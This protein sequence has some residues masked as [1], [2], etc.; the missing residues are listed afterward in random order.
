[1]PPRSAEAGRVA[2]GLLPGI[3]AAWVAFM[4]WHVLPLLWA[5]VL[6]RLSHAGVIR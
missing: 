3:L 1:M 2:A 6:V 5:G 4:A